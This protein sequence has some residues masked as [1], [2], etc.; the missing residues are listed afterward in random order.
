[1][2]INH[3][4]LETIRPNQRIALEKIK[5]AIDGGA[6]F[7][8]LQ[9][10]VG[11]GKSAVAVSLCN[12]YGKGYIA[13]P[14]QS[15]QEQY[16]ADFKNKL[17]VLKGKGAYQ[18]TYGNPTSNKKIIKLI[19]DGD[20]VPKPKLEDSCAT[21]ECVG[22][23]SET[24]QKRI[25]ECKGGSG[26]C[27]Y[28]I[29]LAE[30][31]KEDIVCCN[32]ASFFFNGM[33]DRLEKRRIII[34]DESHGLEAYLRSQ[35][36]VTF[37]V[38]RD[39]PLSDISPLKT[40]LQWVQWLKQDDQFLHTPNDSRE[41]YLEKLEKLEKNIEAYGKL[42][43]V[44]VIQGKHKTVITMIPSYVGNA[45]HQFFGAFGDIVV[46][47]SGTILDKNA[48]FSGLGISPND[49][50]FINI[51][52]DFPKENRP[53]VMPRHSNLDLSH[54]LWGVN[55]P[56]AIHEIRRIMQHHNA[57]KGLIHAA[58][59]KMAQELTSSLSE[60]GRIVT[61]TP[62]TFAQKLQMFYDSKEPLVFISPSIREGIDAHGTRAKWQIIIRPPYPAITDPY[63]HAKLSQGHWVWYNWRTLIDVMQMCGRSTRSKDDSSVVYLLDTRFHAFFQKVN[64]I[65]PQW[66]RD[67]IVK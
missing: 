65:L 15:L 32:T 22:V 49:A 40:P 6:K 37:N 58:S 64:H 31:L 19:R 17:K 62:E 7:I 48:F 50:V 14:T 55:S 12:Y 43:I 20:N 3:F 66:F 36:S 10:A 27:P 30:A 26:D 38:Y 9:A 34:I 56:I 39:V 8:G 33:Y 45:F 67:G 41:A 13:C 18:C 60:T 59:Y 11:L 63:V 23:K 29:A 21:G 46:F 4:P 47:M 16:R 2:P 51:D 53:V 28:D 5:A 25:Q 35:I 61:H 52:S 57:Q 1:M 54:K 42:A 44:E 24:R